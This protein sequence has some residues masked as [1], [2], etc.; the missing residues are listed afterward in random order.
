[1]QKR[2]DIGIENQIAHVR[3]V[4]SDKMNALMI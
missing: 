2:V 3:M 1:M 4:R